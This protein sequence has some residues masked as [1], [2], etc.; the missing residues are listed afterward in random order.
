MDGS[1]HQWKRLLDALV[2]R[3]GPSAFEDQ[4]GEWKNLLKEP[5]FP[6]Y[7]S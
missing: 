7:Q 2:L 6:D 5:L 3:F 4:K 1:I